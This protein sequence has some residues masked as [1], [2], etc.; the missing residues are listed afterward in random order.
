MAEALKRLGGGRWAS[1]DGRFT[2][3]SQS[4]TWA[5]VDNEQTNEFGLPLVRGPYPTLTAA[6]EAIETAKDAGPAES[7]LAE[8]IER[9]PPPKVTAKKE[10]EA[11]PE[12]K[13]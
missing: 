12:P 10:P 11:P 5:L 6:K 1:K 2:I 4:G 3:E 7:P 9:A 8:Q 13:W